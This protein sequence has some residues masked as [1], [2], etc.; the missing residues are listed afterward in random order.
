MKNMLIKEDAPVIEVNIE[1]SIG[2]GYNLQ[3]LEKSDTALPT[4]F[5]EYYNVWIS[6][7]GALC[8]K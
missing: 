5:N 1:T 7:R 8:G 6:S 3:V 2:R 4:L